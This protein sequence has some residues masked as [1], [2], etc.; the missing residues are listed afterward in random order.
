MKKAL[1]LSLLLAAATLPAFALTQPATQSSSSTGT[2]APLA[3]PDEQ[4][5]FDSSKD[6]N[7][8]S[9]GREQSLLGGPSNGQQTY[10]F[11]S[12]GGSMA[13]GFNRGSQFQSSF[14][15]H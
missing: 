3:D 11:N 14:S 6:Y 7:S 8:G 12:P 2:Q 4:D 13:Y 5:N 1:A 9:S 10:G 15:G